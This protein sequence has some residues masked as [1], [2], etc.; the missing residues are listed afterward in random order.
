[1]SYAIEVKRKSF[2]IAGGFKI[3]RETRTHANVVEVTLSD[4]TFSGHGECVPYP[5]YGESIESV[6]QQIEDLTPQLKRGLAR[7]E[8]QEALPAGSARNAVDCAFWD[9]EA[10]KQNKRAFEIAGLK[11]LNT[12]TTAFTISVDSP[13]KMAEKARQAAHRPLLKVKLAGAGDN[14]RIDA[15]RNAAPESR[16]IV[17]ANEAWDEGCFEINMRACAAASVEL[18]EQPLPAKNDDFL[19][20]LPR[21][22]LICADESLNP[23]KNIGEL[24][25]KYD[26]V[27]I[28][29]DKAGGLT[30][31]LQLA[32]DA[33]RHDLKTMVGCMLGSSLAMAPAILVAQHADYVD[34]D[35]PLL[36]SQDRTPGLRFSGSTL[37]PPTPDL[38]G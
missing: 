9:L 36:L 14:E 18:V 17:D 15:V 12:L 16:L 19:N 37:Y 22:V 13:Q 25:G 10:K 31:A 4:G 32:V 1:M 5:R 24:K 7:K 8:L 3:S 35:G 6:C 27:N 20:D 28:K 23:G 33:R 29:L 21:T 30:A 11:K 34:L 2:K 26:A 38:W